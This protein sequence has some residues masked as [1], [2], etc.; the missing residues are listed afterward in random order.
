MES[1]FEYALSYFAKYDRHTKENKSSSHPP[2]KE[3]MLFPEYLYLQTNENNSDEEKS[4]TKDKFTLE[5]D[6]RLLP[7]RKQFEA[8][9]PQIRVDLEKNVFEKS[10]L[11]EIK[12]QSYMKTFIMI[13]LGMLEYNIDIFANENMGKINNSNET[14]G[15]TLNVDALLFDKILEGSYIGMKELA[16]ASG[17]AMDELGFKKN[18]RIITEREKQLLPI[19][20]QK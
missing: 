20:Q 18:V 10:N 12:K 7:P 5:I 6:H 17:F 1:R 13:Y 15:Y 16:I 11:V 9:V 3:P 14:T 2:C 4:Y 19:L 8:L